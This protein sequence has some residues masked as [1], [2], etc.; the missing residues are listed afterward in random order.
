MMWDRIIT[1]CWLPLI[2]GDAALI[3]IMGTGK[4]ITPGSASK[5]V[6]IPSI[7]YQM[8]SDIE[9]ENFNPVQIQVDYW[10]KGI[11]A[12]R[13]AERRLRLLTA[14]DTSRVLGGIRMWTKYLDSRSHD[15]PAD[16][17]VVHRSIDFEFSAL[18]ERFQTTP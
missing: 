4:F 9:E 18:K 3:R 11:K 13:A 15:Y 1:D 2:E 16:P 6:T 8:F 10:I 14:R 5:P 17:G 12:A 7:Q